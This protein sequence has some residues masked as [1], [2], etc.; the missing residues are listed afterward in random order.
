MS[1]T[2][3]QIAKDKGNA[4]FKS[5]NWAEAVGHY[6][7]AVLADRTE[8]TYPLNRAA[9]Y[10]KLGKYLDAERDCTTVLGLDGKNVKALFR[11]AQ[12]RLALERLPEAEK[13]LL[14]ATEIDPSNSSV[15]TELDTVKKHKLEI[16]QKQKSAQREPITVPP[17]TLSSE[18]DARSNLKGKE[19]SSA[20]R[21]I[22]DVPIYIVEP[23]ELAS[24]RENS[25]DL[26]KPIHSRILSPSPV[27]SH[28][29]TSSTSAQKSQPRVGAAIFRAD[30]NHTMLRGP[31]AE[32]STPSAPIPPPPATIAKPTKHTMTYSAVSPT[33]VP[34]PSSSLTYFAF[35]RTWNALPMPQER[36]SLLT[37][38][39]PESLPA[40]FQNS[41]EP[42]FLVSILKFFEAVASPATSHILSLYMSA[43]TL[44]PRFKTILLFLSP[45]EKDIA[46]AVW[47]AILPDGDHEGRRAWGL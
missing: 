45:K 26:L 35:T 6:S 27:P 9:A 23:D 18:R 21:V 1:S 13:D 16:A 41:L 2:M 17:I 38:V 4:A 32:P 44:I 24:I 11:R 28:Q 22:R 5:S 3:A 7:A 47:D 31:I 29:P 30:G 10:L 12:A 43:L 19:A 14:R 39:P 46:R 33:N 8:P 40:L 20:R 25:N 36:Y 42:E 34:T 37:S 15:K